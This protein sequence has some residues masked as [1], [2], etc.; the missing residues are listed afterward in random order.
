[1]PVVFVVVQLPGM[2]RVELSMKCF[3]ITE[4]F[5]ALIRVQF[6]ALQEACEAQ[7]VEHAP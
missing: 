3:A 4:S 6:P 2:A 5:S 7:F 1:M